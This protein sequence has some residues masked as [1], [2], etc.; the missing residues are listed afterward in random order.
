GALGAAVRARVSGLPPTWMARASVTRAF[1]LPQP[2]VRSHGNNPLKFSAD[3]EDALRALLGAGRRTNMN[4]AE[5]VADALRDVR[6]HELATMV[7]MQSAVR[8]LLEELDPAKLRRSAE[9]AGPNLVP[10]QRKANP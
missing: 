5:A 3:N 1:R 6:L 8:A 2:M 9:R 10:L 7:A 4:A